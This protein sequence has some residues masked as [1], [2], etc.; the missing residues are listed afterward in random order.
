MCN[1]WYI[2][3][4]NNDAVTLSSSMLVYIF[5]FMWHALV[6]LFAC[7][8]LCQIWSVPHAKYTLF[9]RVYR[10]K[11]IKLALKLFFF[12]YISGFVALSARTS[13]RFL[14]LAFDDALNSICT[15]FTMKN[16]CLVLQF[17]TNEM[18]TIS[19]S[20]VY[21]PEKMFAHFFCSHDFY[22][23]MFAGHNRDH[24]ANR[25]SVLI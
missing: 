1:Q 19:C 6:R 24:N 16:I 12:V 23:G 21:L 14:Y 2:Y 13:M 10:R 7:E 9:A 17:H 4:C 15:T 18:W 25:W 8:R 11:K 3:G 22:R 5:I 20:D